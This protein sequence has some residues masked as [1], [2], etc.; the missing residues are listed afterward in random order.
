MQTTFLHGTYYIPGQRVLRSEDLRRGARRSMIAKPEVSESK[1]SQAHK[2]N[3]DLID[4]RIVHER[5]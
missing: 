2:L 1:D 3:V 5:D 4:K